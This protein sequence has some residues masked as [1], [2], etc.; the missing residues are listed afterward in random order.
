MLEAR[1]RLD[2]RD[3]L[4]RHAQL[5]ERAERRLLVGTKVAHRLV[6]ADEALLD[7]VLRVAAGEEVRAR[8]Q[9]DEG[10]V[11]ADQLVH[12]D[13]RA[14]PRLQDELQILEL[15]LNLLRR[16]RCDR[17]A[18]GHWNTPGICG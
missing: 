12:G 16:L 18:D 9:P 6:E 5:R 2:R 10:R 7:Q 3:D 1:R 13:A 17:G 11:P 4:P 15:S 8:L 14:V